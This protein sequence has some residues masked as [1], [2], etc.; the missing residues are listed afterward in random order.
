MRWRRA[1]GWSILALAAALVLLWTFGPR[2]TMDS[3]ITF[4][5]AQMG[6]DLDSYLARQE[7]RFPDITP[8]VQ[9]RIV[10]A[11]ADGAQTDVAVVYLHGFSATSQEIRPVPDEV[12][13]AL[14]ANLFYTRLAGHGRGG[15]AMATATTGKWMNDLAEALAIG[16]RIGRKVLVIATSTGG[17]LA[18]VGATDPRLKDEIQGL[19]LISPNF[20]VN[21]PAAALLTMPFA[22]WWGPIVAGRERAFT[23]RNPRQAKYWTTRYPTAALFPMGALVAYADRQDYAHAMQP[24]LFIYAPADQVVDERET[25]RIAAEWGGPHQVAKRTMGP[26]DDPSSHVIA[27]DILSPGQTAGTVKLILDWARAQGF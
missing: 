13:K 17:T 18:A 5:P 27:G 3:R 6:P 11:G 4:N 26:K 19:V 22:R 2:A 24:A 10:W 25:A 23:P 12:A 1:A 9:K 21:S 15:A 8:G 16:H 7:A 20:R 14:G